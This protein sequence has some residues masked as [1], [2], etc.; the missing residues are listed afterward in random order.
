[1]LGVASWPAISRREESR[2]EASGRPL[3][4]SISTGSDMGLETK[5]VPFS[6]IGKCSSS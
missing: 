4:A 6:S 3:I 1:M 2:S 5:G